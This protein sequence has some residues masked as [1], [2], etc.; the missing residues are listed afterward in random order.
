MRWIFWAN[1]CI[2]GCA[3]VRGVSTSEAAGGSSSVDAA[4]GGSSGAPAGNITATEIA[5]GAQHVCALLR[6]Q[7]IWC[8]GDNSFGQLGNGTTTNDGPGPVVGISNA[9][10]VAAGA[11]QTCAVL[12][13]GQAAS[14]GADGS[15]SPDYFGI[16]PTP[17]TVS[18]LNAVAALAA[19]DEHSCAVLG[20]GTVQCWG[21]NDHGQLG[22]GAPPGAGYHSAAAVVSGISTASRVSAGYQF[23][24]ALLGDGSARCW[25]ANQFGQLGNGTTIDSPV[26]VSVSA[27]TDAVSITSNVN[28]TCVLQQ[29]GT[30]QCW[31][32][33]I[34]S[35]VTISGVDSAAAIFV[36]W[37]ALDDGRVVQFQLDNSGPLS[38]V[39]GISNATSVVANENAVCVLLGD[40]SVHCWNEFSDGGV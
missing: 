19:G 34:E 11:F 30:I 13:G 17:K 12:D 37:T 18:G 24:C 14:W 1:L 20:S 2:V 26:P 27:I 38:V 29:L 8:W 21:H 33:G 16:S 4:G 32:G 22:T 28:Q 15:G 40:A 31:G 10:A 6:D 3:N 5:S 9:T 23:A 39:G 7:T 36:G 35:P 25:G